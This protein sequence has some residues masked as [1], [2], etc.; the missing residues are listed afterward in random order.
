MRSLFVTLA[1]LSWACA[2]DDGSPLE[3]N[4]TIEVKQ[5]DVAPMTAARVVRVLVDEGDVVRQGDTVVT[6]EQTTLPSDIEQ[7]RSRVAAAEAA[8]RDLQAGARPAEIERAEAEL[9]AAEAEA[10]RTARDVE[11]FRPLV[12]S[13]SVSQQQ[14][15]AAIAAA[16][17]AAGA[18]DAAREALRLA[19]QGARPQQ[20]QAAR[21]EVAAARAALDAARATASDLLLLAPVDGTVLSRHAEPGEVLGAAQS[22]LTI[23]ETAQ[24]W[25]RVYVN[26]RVIPRLN[27]GD[28]AT[29]VLDGLPDRPL[30][31]RV[32][33]ISPRAEFT[34]RVALT[35]EERADLVFGVKVELLDGITLAKAGLPATV[36]LH[37]SSGNV[38]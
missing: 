1:L 31:G 19:R 17:S 5:A 13:G 20:V 9:R 18:R 30:R 14:L 35:E 6:L 22:A 29:V 25:V 24:P 3:V 38:Q 8:L 36:R 4:G 12:A 32:S 27:V 28:T 2:G 15:D 37:P 23:G 33:A 34:P 16:R 10:V 11:R 21:A 7:R 26:Q